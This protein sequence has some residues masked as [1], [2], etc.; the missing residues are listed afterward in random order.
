MT[1]NDLITLVAVLVVWFFLT[2]VV[3]PKLGIQSC[4]CG[5]SCNL[6]NSNKTKGDKNV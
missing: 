6:D 4:C 5:D 2:R 3:F 1:F